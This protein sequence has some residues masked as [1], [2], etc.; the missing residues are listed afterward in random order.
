MKDWRIVGIALVATTAA[1]GTAQAITDTIF[2]YSSPKTG[3]L[4]I[5]PAALS[6][7]ADGV[8]YIIGFSGGVHLQTN[9]LQCFVT[10]V[11]LPHGARITQMLVFYTTGGTGPQVR[12]YRESLTTGVAQQIANA[13]LPLTGGAR[14]AASVPI[15]PSLA[16]VGNAAFTYGFGTCLSDTAN[17]LHG[18]RITYTYTNA[19][20]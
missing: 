13:N 1:I 6:P 18:V 4:T 12:L 14:S 2:Q 17:T 16:I 15:A 9:S 11:N 20:D 8:D 3:Y 10:G 7:T 19:G 5:S